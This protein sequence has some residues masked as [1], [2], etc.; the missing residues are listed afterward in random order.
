MSALQIGLIVAGVLLVIGVFAFNRWQMRKIE[1]RGAPV[2]RTPDVR[3][4]APERVEP[5]L[6]AGAAAAAQGVTAPLR[7]ASSRQA[8]ISAK[9]PGVSLASRSQS[10]RGSARPNQRR[11]LPMRAAKPLASAAAATGAAGCSRIRHSIS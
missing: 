4:H 1:R 3:T 2:A 9:R 6:G 5:T 7:S 8:T 10:E 11:G